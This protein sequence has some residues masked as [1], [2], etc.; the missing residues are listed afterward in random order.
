MQ[1]GIVISE[2]SES[3]H[4]LVLPSNAKL[5][6]ALP[7]DINDTVALTN[8]PWQQSLMCLKRLPKDVRTQLCLY[9]SWQAFLTGRLH[10]FQNLSSVIM[11]SPKI[12]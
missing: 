2:Q 5:T 8:D 9:H 3:P 11:S 1:V 12:A 6:S 7:L 10:S 4:K